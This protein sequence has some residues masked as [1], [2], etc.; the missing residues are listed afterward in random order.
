MLLEWLGTRAHEGGVVA[1][2]SRIDAAVRRV[3]GT[4]TCTPDLGGSASTT[5]FT[6]A[7]VA[8]LTDPSGGKPA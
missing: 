2:G 5:E 8:A 3:V 1:A 6:A 7:V 4:G